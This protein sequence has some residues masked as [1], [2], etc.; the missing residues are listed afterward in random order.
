MLGIR[1]G[2]MPQLD[3]ALLATRVAHRNLEPID[4]LVPLDLA[5]AAA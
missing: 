4:L 3:S 1:I 5:I 2:L